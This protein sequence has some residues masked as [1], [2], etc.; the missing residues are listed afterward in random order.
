M[1]EQTVK[2]VS[3]VILT[4][5]GVAAIYMALTAFFNVL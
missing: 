3:T 4:L 1:E 2:I 5:A